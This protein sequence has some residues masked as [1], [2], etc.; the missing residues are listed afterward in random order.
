MSLRQGWALV[1]KNNE[2]LDH[3]LGAGWSPK[4]KCLVEVHSRLKDATLPCL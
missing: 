2:S 1:T 3:D 4:T